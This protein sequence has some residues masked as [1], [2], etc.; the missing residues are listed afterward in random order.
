MYCTGTLCKLPLYISLLQSIS[1][2]LVRTEMPPQKFLD[3]LPSLNPEDIAD[4]VLYALGAPPHV[5]VCS[6]FITGWA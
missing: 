3:I 2:G 1:P 5:Q 6:T 4:G